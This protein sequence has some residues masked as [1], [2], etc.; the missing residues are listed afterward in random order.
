MGELSIV[1]EDESNM[2]N[3]W[4]F[5][6]NPAGFLAD[7]R[8]SV[9]RGDVLWTRHKTTNLRYYEYYYSGYTEY[10]A[11][12]DIFDTWVSGSFRSDGDYA[13]G[14]EGNYFY[15]ET[16]SRFERQEQK[17]PK[18]LLIFSNNINS[19][20]SFGANLGYFED[21]YEYLIET[22]DEEVGHKAKSWCAEI[23]VGRKFSPGVILGAFLGYDSF[24]PEEDSDLS[25][26]YSIWLS[27]QTVVE[28]DERLKLGIETSFKFERADFREGKHVEGEEK[29]KQSHYFSRLRFRGIYDFSPEFRVGLFFSNDEPFLG[30]YE[31]V[32]WSFPFPS[33]EFTSSHW[34]AGCSYRFSK[35][36]V[37]GV[38]Y[39]FRDFPR[40]RSIYYHEPG[41]KTE[42]L[43]LGVEGEVAEDFFLRGGFIRTETNQ[44]PNLDKLRDSWE[45]ALTLGFGYEPYGRNLTFEFSYRYAYKKFKQWYSDWDVKSG[46]HVLSLSLKK[47]L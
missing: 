1:I 12:G 8:G 33:Y 24:H 27:G 38:E 37:G 2:I 26:S 35:R 40:P 25:D 16:D 21:D 13:L 36:V 3:L 15:R 39:H 34:G 29:E 17:T 7:E 11:N 23:G 45:N 20:T 28:I 9:I 42:S 5:A 6:R 18:I 14:V 19:L 10:S 44:N 41:W 4:D 43:N 30:F 32:Y 31:P 22:W 47:V 46:R